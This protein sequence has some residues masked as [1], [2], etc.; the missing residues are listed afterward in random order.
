MKR[1]M[2]LMIIAL[3]VACVFAGSAWAQTF[4]F[5]YVDF[6]KFAADSKRHQQEQKKLADL[7]Q[8]KQN[9][10]E[11]K[12]EELIKLQEDLQKQGPLL[13]EDSRNAKLKDIGIKEM[14]FKLQEQ[15]AKNLV[16]NAQREA[17]EILR[18]DMKEIMDKIRAD[19]KYT[20]IFDAAALVSADKAMD[21]TDQ[22]V[23]AYDSAKPSAKPAAST[24]A[25]AKPKAPVGP[26]K[27]AERR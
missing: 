1:S 22:V 17:M 3:A 14:E 7:V 16:Q 27:P 5:A 13:S 24:P 19:Q 12:K 20:F 6:Q 26:A 11:K 2:A 15:Q 9:D 4:K 25:P 10:L 23:S 21:I 18:R 8:M